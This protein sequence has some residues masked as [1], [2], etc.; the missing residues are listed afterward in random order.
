MI[1]LAMIPMTAKRGQVQLHTLLILS[2]VCSSYASSMVAECMVWAWLFSIVFFA[3]S[4]LTGASDC[5][6]KL[7]NLSLGSKSELRILAFITVAVVLI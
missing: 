2:L 1:S 4:L 5:Y 3:C 6:S 7:L